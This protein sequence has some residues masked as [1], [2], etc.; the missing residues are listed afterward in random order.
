LQKGECYAE[1]GF[2]Y[3]VNVCEKVN[4]KYSE[5]SAFDDK[6][7]NVVNSFVKGNPEIGTLPGFKVGILTTKGD[8][9]YEFT[10]EANTDIEPEELLG[11]I[12]AKRKELGNGLESVSLDSE[13]LYKFLQYASK[14]NGLSPV[15]IPSGKFNLSVMDD[16]NFLLT[17]DRKTKS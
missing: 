3:G 17:I 15:G 4:G 7:S 13:Q 16:G 12:V 9:Y 8:T 1:K 10:P 2:V 11:I 5:L 14:N 6:N